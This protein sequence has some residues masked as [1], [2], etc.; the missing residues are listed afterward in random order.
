MANTKN[1]KSS[2]IRSNEYLPKAGPKSANGGRNK[3][4]GRVGNPSEPDILT[5]AKQD[6]IESDKQRRA[7]QFAN[8]EEQKRLR[9]AKAKLVAD[10][11]AEKQAKFVEQAELAKT[12]L[13]ME[14]GVTRNLALLMISNF[15]AVVPNSTGVFVGYSPSGLPS[16]RTEAAADLAVTQITAQ[17]ALNDST[18]KSARRASGKALTSA[19]YR[20]KDVVVTDTV[21][22]RELTNA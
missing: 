8:S 21:K 16:G 6:R 11:A 18:I 17:R 4:R 19:Y 3:R 9:E 10:L 13:T 5:A 7:M 14:A 12:L 1:K 20:L 22:Q 2:G 15:S